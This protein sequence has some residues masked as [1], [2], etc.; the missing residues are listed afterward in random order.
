MTASR[1]LARRAGFAAAAAL[2]FA[3]TEAEVRAEVDASGD[4]AEVA[5][6][7]EGGAEAG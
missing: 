2:F 1:A 5:A 6:A 4:L 7:D 3:A